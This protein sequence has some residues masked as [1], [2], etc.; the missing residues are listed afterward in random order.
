MQPTFDEVKGTNKNEECR[1]LELTYIIIFIIGGF[2][3]I[4][5]WEEWILFCNFA[6]Q[7]YIL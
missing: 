6:A 4:K 2:F 5:Y 3:S 7:L 1:I